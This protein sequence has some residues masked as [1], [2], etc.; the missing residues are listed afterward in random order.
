VKALVARIE[1]LAGGRCFEII[2]G[3]SVEAKN[4]LS[5]R[6]YWQ[7]GGFSRLRSALALGGK[8]KRLYFTEPNVRRAL[9][10]ETVP[11]SPIAAMLCPAADEACGAETAG[12]ELRVEAL[13][14]LAAKA[15]RF[16][17]RRQDHDC[18]R[19]AR[20]APRSKQ[21]D[22]WRGCLESDDDVAPRTNLPI[23]RTRAPRRGWFVIKGRRGHYDFCDELRAYDLATGS[24]YVAGSCSG[25][26]LENDG[27]VNGQKT[28]AARRSVVTIGS[29]ARP[30]ARGGMDGAVAR[31]A[32]RVSAS[33]QRRHGSP[34]LDRGQA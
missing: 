25:L 33:W 27:S 19:V 4:G 30:T 29:A 28:D 13:F 10:L 20:A 24:A 8:G 31:R 17:T 7:D 5:L 23:G 34:G 32:G 1:K 26:A 12:W 21:F 14:A 6:T 15:P 16:R 11:A 3:A 2:E 9:T 18:E 22:V